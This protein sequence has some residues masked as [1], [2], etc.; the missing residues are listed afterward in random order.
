MN[1]T[2][3]TVFVVDD[4]REVRVGLSR[5]LTAAGYQVRAFVHYQ[6]RLRGWG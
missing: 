6:R 3:R 5:V 2:A 1:G 4:V